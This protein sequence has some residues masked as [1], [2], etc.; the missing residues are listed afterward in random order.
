MS[1]ASR[2]QSTQFPSLVPTLLVAAIAVYGYYTFRADLNSPRPK[3]S[4][5]ARMPSPA[6][7]EGFETEF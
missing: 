5:P 6:A 3:S 7:P 2:P 1:N 4:E